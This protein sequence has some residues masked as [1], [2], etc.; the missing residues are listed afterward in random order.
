MEISIIGEKKN[1]LRVKN[2]E[3]L[4]KL[5]ALPVNPGIYIFKD[6]NDKVIYVGKAKNLRSRV[7][8][9]FTCADDGRYQYPRLVSSIHDVEVILA[10]SEV[11]ALR[12]EAAVIR[13]HQPR[14]NV[15]L[16][17]DKSYPFLKITRE[18]FPRVTF[19]R[20][21]RKKNAD[22]FGPYTD[23]RS[24]NTLIRTLK[25]LL[26]IRNCDLPLTPEKIAQNRFKLCLDFHIGRCGGPCVGKV[27][28]D[29]Y[30]KGIDRFIQFLHGR[31]DDI[32][33]DLEQEMR[34]YSNALQY[35][36]AAAIR[37]R[38]SAARRFTERQV[39]VDPNPINQD[40]LG[41]VREDS[42]AA[43]SVLKVR[44][45]RIVGQSPF[46]MERITG[47]SDA[48]ILE[49]FLVHHYDIVDSVPDE[50]FLPVEPLETESLI[51]YISEAAGHKV[52]LIVPKRGE[53]HSLLKLAAANAELLLTEKRL[54]ADKR[55]FIPRSARALQECLHL[56]EAPLRIEAFDVSNL[57]GTDC[58]ASMVSYRDG[59]PFKSGY[60]VFK[61]KSVAGID[62]FASIREAVKRRYSRLLKDISD[63]QKLSKEE[64]SDIKKAD[65]PQLP[66]LVLV[67]G[68]AG[69]LS[70]AKEILDEI[71]LS[72]QPVVGLAKRLE[73]VYLP[74]K[75]DPMI[76]S[77][78]SSAL[79]LLQQIRDEAHRF[80]VSRHRMLRGK[81]Q[82]KS[83]LDEIPGI[84]PSRR[85]ALLRKFGSIK[86]IAAAP[87]EEIAAVK[88]MTKK[89]AEAVILELNTLIQR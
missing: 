56:K 50:I 80:A 89:A 1:S 58:V 7:R 47:L 43:F 14:Y 24:T 85:Q 42:F 62:D 34:E 70:S 3:L 72:D 60:R 13:L 31:H 23:V 22:Y 46:H 18:P 36:E 75:K 17:D 52:R 11:E 37:D 74:G 86:R 5:E 10:R 45:G 88:G 66:D 64:K 27:S 16:R 38:L 26:H 49:T 67:D 63:F 35:E 61:I 21:P 33:A 71:G 84:G 69:Q 30:R 53:K 15:D 48:A 54:M 57:M 25:G 59:K 44:S 40:V 2:S 28:D 8:S 77:R 73:E 68:G 79:K 9:Y 20:K 41:F 6:R 12:T 51:A 39:K 76:L 83:R 82:V 78:S 4:N 87:T 29:T 81:R 65:I 19:T 55:D 32:L